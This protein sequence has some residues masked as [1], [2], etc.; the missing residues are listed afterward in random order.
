MRRAE[1]D[2]F[3]LGEEVVRPAV[4]DHPADDLERNQLFRNEL[5]RVE[6]VEGKR[7]RLFLG[8]ELDRELPFGKCAR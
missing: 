5:G 8:E 7:I 1:G 4:E 3:G 2:L 6:V